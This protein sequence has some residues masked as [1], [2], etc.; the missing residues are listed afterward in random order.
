METF[1]NDC[2][3][4]E[5]LRWLTGTLPSRPQVCEARATRRS[6]EP[7]D[8]SQTSS[9]LT[10]ECLNLPLRSRS[11]DLC[12]CGPGEGVAIQSSCLCLEL[13]FKGVLLTS[14]EEGGCQPKGCSGSKR[15]WREILY[16]CTQKHKTS[17][18]LVS[19]CWRSF[20]S[21]RM[22]PLSPRGGSA[23]LK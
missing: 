20:S 8:L 17:H 10:S 9:N 15:N 13:S 22:S 6:D 23:G 19:R 18:V 3:G 4:N 16:C 2:W 14:S 7:C 21:K 5:Y 12:R 11:A 1:R